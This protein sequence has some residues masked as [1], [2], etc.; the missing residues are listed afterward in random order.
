MINNDELKDLL[1]LRSE[2]CTWKTRLKNRF[3][4]CSDSK[5]DIKC[6]QEKVI[7]LFHTPFILF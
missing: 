4:N 5:K 7:N 3:S 6:V 2:I 1:S